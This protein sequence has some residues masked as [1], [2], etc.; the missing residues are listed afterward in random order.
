MNVPPNQSNST[1]SF[2]NETPQ[3]VGTTE[4]AQTDRLVEEVIRRI[5]PRIMER[6]TGMITE[7]LACKCC[8]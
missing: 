6:I 2:Q 1:S 8:S 5:G 7:A 3:A 4:D